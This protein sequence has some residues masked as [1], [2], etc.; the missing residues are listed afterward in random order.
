MITSYEND[1]E[2]TDLLWDLFDWLKSLAV[3]ERVWAGEIKLA[4]D[5]FAQPEGDAR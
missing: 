5:A 1:P 4:G 2:G 3:W